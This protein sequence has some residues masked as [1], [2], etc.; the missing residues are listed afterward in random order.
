MEQIRKV[1]WKQT[2]LQ[3]AL[4]WEVLLAHVYRRRWSS[5]RCLEIWSQWYLK[6]EPHPTWQPLLEGDSTNEDTHTHTPLLKTNGCIWSSW[7]S[8]SHWNMSIL[9]CRC[10][11]I[12]FVWKSHYFSRHWSKASFTACLKTLAI[13]HRRRNKYRWVWKRALSYVWRW[14][15]LHSGNSSV[16]YSDIMKP[17]PPLK[18]PSNK[19]GLASEE[20]ETNTSLW[21][22][23]RLHK[24]LFNVLQFNLNTIRSAAWQFGCGMTNNRSYNRAALTEDGLLPLFQKSEAW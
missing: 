18:N 3:Q 2:G 21:S 1:I 10:G 20:I 24:I 8:S 6:W 22:G 23:V 12:W 7:I 13:L 14:K 5:Q 9:I 19:I 16:L 15:I 17:N 4:H 11:Q